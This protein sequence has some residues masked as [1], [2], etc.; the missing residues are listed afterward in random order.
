[1]V[2]CERFAGLYGGTVDRFLMLNG[3]EIGIVF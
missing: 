2:N 3:M 1:M